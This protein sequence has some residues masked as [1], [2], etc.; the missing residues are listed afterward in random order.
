MNPFEKYLGKEDHLQ[1]QVCEYLNYQYPKVFWC[2][3][4]NG[5]K[6]SPF[7]SYKAQKLGLK[8]GLPDLMIFK[9]KE[10]YTGMIKYFISGLFIEL[11]IKPN[12]PQASQIL[13]MNELKK[14]GWAGGVCYSF[15]EAKKLIDNYLK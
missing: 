3:I 9:Q 5:G 1:F 15:E 13:A 14:N 7:E 11:K 10:S 12:K 6:R 4:P 2:H 8:S